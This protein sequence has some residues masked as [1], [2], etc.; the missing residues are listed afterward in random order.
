MAITD[1]LICKEDF[2][3]LLFLYSEYIIRYLDVIHFGPFC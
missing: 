3:S 1:E 2:V